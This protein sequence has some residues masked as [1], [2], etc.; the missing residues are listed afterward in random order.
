[1]SDNNNKLPVIAIVVVI[2]ALAG[3]AMFYF[4]K[5]MTKDTTVA[6]GTEAPAHSTDQAE[7]SEPADAAKADSSPDDDQAVDADAATASAGGKEGTFNGVPVK[8]GNPVVAKVDGKDVTRVDVYRYI[9][10]MPENVQQLPPG[11][12]YPLALEQVINT[13][14][15]QNQAEAADLENDSEVKKQLAMAKQQIERAV[16]IQRA[17]DKNISESDLKA[18]YDEFVKKAPDVEEIHASHIL[19]DSEQKA[20]DIIAKLGKGE[21]FETLAKEN[22]A[23]KTGANGGDL[24]WFSKQDMVPEFANATFALKKGETSKTPVK[25]QFGWHVIKVTDSRS[26]PK[27]SFE[28]VK[29]YLQV[30]LRRQTLEKMLED[31]RAKAKIEKFDINGDPVSAEPAAGSDTSPAIAV[32]A[33]AKTE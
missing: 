30:D 15:V 11:A 6:A 14:L 16:Y 27:P 9:R 32:P 22:S 23:D 4:S 26:R 2:L 3:G 31:W 8:P 7:A 19:V 33:P 28:E 25:T 12:V 17:V 10:M 5:N 29:P 1:M 24:G 20:K 21:S 13:R 18:A